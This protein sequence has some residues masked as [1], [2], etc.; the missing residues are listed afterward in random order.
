LFPQDTLERVDGDWLCGVCR[1]PEERVADI[2]EY[3]ARMNEDLGL[4]I[5]VD[6]VLAH[7]ARVDAWPVCARCE[8]KTSPLALKLV[9][10]WPHDD[11]ELVCQHCIEDP[12]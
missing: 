1:L 2:R 8:E 3:V 7:A 12:G 10:R 4:A 9:L 6:D 11:G 5:K